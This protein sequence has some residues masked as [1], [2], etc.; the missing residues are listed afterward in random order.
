M[1][2]LYLEGSWEEI[3]KKIAENTTETGVK[4]LKYFMDTPNRMALHIAQGNKILHS[5]VAKSIELLARKQVS[6]IP[7]EDKALLKAVA[8]GLNIPE[9]K[10]LSSFVLPDVLNYFASKGDRVAKRFIPPF[11]LGCSSIVAMGSA[12]K[13][14]YTYHGRNLDYFGGKYWEKGHCIMIIKPLKGTAFV[15]VTTEGIYCPGVTTVN[16]EGISV[17][18]HL[19]FTRSVKANNTPVTATASMIAS[20]AKSLSEAIDIIRE[21]RPMAGWTFIVADAKAK[22]AAIIETCAD[23]ISISLPEHQS[24]WY[25]NCYISQEQKEREYAPSYTWVENN[26][27]RL[28]RLKE[29][30]LTNLKKLDEEKIVEILGDTFDITIQKDV[31]LGHTVSNAANISSA[32][33]SWDKDAIWVSSSPVPVNRGNFKGYR[34]SS[35]LEGS[36]EEISNIEGKR[37]PE[38]KEKAFRTFA[39]FCSLWEE[40]ASAMDCL[41]LID[42]V[43]EED[44]EEPLYKL[45]RAWILAKLKRYEEALE[46]LS[47]IEETQLCPSRRAQVYLWLGR[48]HDLTGSRAIAVDYY[49]KAIR[50]FPSMDIQL[51]AWEGIRK[52]YKEKKLKKLDILPFIAEHIDL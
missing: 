49:H 4:T 38:Y 32:V 47:S 40:T 28:N 15:S 51:A 50:A 18:L 10:L 37:L 3:G 29:L 46:D 20:R 22:E 19:N 23:K 13:D 52:G 45:V 31:A 9:G 2:L 44:P 43:V 16:E 35:L 24:L 39:E 42:K 41:H 27:A 25:T 30:V 17:S 7:S 33:M 11:L 26:N 1:K 36:P 6:K 21:N 8:Q 14:G 5:V 12:T 48:L 34:L